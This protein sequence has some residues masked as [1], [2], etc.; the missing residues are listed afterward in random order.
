[1]PGT[2]AWLAAAAEQ[3]TE[4]TPPRTTPARQRPQRAPPKPPQQRLAL[5]PVDASPRTPVS[6]NEWMVDSVMALH[7]AARSAVEAVDEAKTPLTAM[8]NAEAAVYKQQLE[9]ESPRRI[10]A[11]R[12]VRQLEGELEATRRALQQTVR[13]YCATPASGPVGRASESGAEGLLEKLP[14]TAQ[15]VASSEAAEKAY[16]EAKSVARFYQGEVARMHTLL[17]HEALKRNAAELQ[18]E[19]CAQ[20]ISDLRATLE[21]TSRAVAAESSSAQAALAEQLSQAAAAQTQERAELSALRTVSGEPRQSVP[22]PTRCGG[23]SAPG[24]AR[25]DGRNHSAAASAA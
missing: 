22:H 9:E 1:M 11:E 6:R 4:A 15:L 20:T 7:S 25:G 5:E 2:P 13:M 16:E 18:A 19:R 24:S 17:E 3:A 12:R 21:Q 8:F 14:V 23:R 10:A